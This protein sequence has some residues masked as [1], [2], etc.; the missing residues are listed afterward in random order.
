M[1]SLYL[2]TVRVIFLVILPIKF[3]DRSLLKNELFQSVW[4][5]DKAYVA[6]LFDLATHPPVCVK[7]LKD[8]EIVSDL[9]AH[10]ASMDGTLVIQAAIIHHICS[11]SEGNLSA[12]LKINTA[13]KISDE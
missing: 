9:E 4:G 13:L 7:L 10:S 12:S 11:N 3:P 8:M 6:V 2:K 1:M 5:R